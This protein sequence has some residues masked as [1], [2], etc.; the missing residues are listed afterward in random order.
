MEMGILRV[1]GDEACCCC[2]MDAKTE[3]HISRK[4]WRVISKGC[5]TCFRART[6]TSNLAVFGLSGG[7]S[8]CPTRPYR[9]HRPKLKDRGDQKLSH[10]VLHCFHCCFEYSGIFPSSASL[11]SLVPTAST[12]RK[13]RL[14]IRPAWSWRLRLLHASPPSYLV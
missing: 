4:P 13:P 14:M 8:P 7:V 1:M 3:S 2:L 10:I 11:L 9:S 12:R 5:A 6:P